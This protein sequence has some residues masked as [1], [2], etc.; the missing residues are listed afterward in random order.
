MRVSMQGQEAGPRPLIYSGSLPRALAHVSLRGRVV[1]VGFEE[2]LSV[3]HE[4][5]G[6]E[7]NIEHATGYQLRFDVAGKPELVDMLLTVCWLG[8]SD[9]MVEAVE[10]DFVLLNDLPD[11]TD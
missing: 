2:F 10:A 7:L 9:A 5:L 11:Q 6:L 8:P 4:R 1:G 3:Y